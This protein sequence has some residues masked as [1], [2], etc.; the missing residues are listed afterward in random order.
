MDCLPPN[1]EMEFEQNCFKCKTVDFL[2]FNCLK[3]SHKY[4]QP[5][6]FP[7]Y[8]DCID[9]DIQV[10][11]AVKPLQKQKCA[12]DGC[13]HADIMIST[14]RHCFKVYCLKHRHQ[15]DHSCP[16]IVITP[17]KEEKRKVELK[18]K[19]TNPKLEL[20][21]LKLNAK[22]DV[23]IPMLN[24]VYLTVIDGS[25]KSNLFYN[26]NMIIGRLVDIL[27]SR[28]GIVN[29]NNL[30]GTRIALFD[31]STGLMLEMS[32]TLQ[33]LVSSNVIYNGS[34]VILKQTESDKIDVF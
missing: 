13:D 29:R 30:G 25:T 17:A 27:A 1:F 15:A 32:K 12:L 19:K 33:D 26:Q 34:T 10:G 20:M 14:C 4:C 5:H 2:L 23:Q 7:S 24:R 11:K 28:S 8:H 6:R 21:R 3:C 16:A 22:G 9:E 18:M 31:G